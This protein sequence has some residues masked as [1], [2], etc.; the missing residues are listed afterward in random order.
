MTGNGEEATWPQ[1]DGTRATRAPGARIGAWVSGVLAA[2]QTR[3]AL[4]LPV[5]FGAG[6]GGYF[7]LATEPPIWAAP[8]FVVLA[9]IA[10]IV[11]RRH[12]LIVGIALAAT[13]AG[14]GVTVV[15]WRALSVA[16]PVLERRIGPVEVSGRVVAIDIRPADRR[17]VLDRVTLSGLE[18]AHTPVRIRV[19]MRKAPADLRPGDRV[20]LRAML[21]P[22]P[23]PAAPGAYDFQRQAWFEQLGAVGYALGAVRRTARG[24]ETTSGWRMRLDAVRLAMVERVTATLPGP[25][26]AVTATLLTGEQ[27]VVPPAEM[28][29]IR[30]SGLAHLLAISGLHVSLVAGIV[31][32]AI[33]GGLALVPPVALRYPIKKWA[34]VAAFVAI[35]LYALF[36]V[37][38]VPV[39]RAWLM[40]GVVLFAILIDRT[41][42]SMRL[43]GWAAFAVL[44]LAPESILSPSFQMSFAAVVALIAGWEALRGRFARWRA[45][46]GFGRRALQGLSAVAF[47]TF[48]AGMAS[49]PYALYHFNRFTLYGLVANLIAVPLTGLWVMPWAVMVYVLAPFGLDGPAL[50]AMGWGVEGILAVARMVAGWDGAVALLPAMPVWGLGAVTLG[51]LWLCL[52]QRGWQLAGVPVILLGLASIPLQRGPDVLVAGDA[53]LVAVR[54][55]DGLLQLSAQRAVRMTRETW[56]RRAGQDGAVLWPKDGIGIDGRLACDTDGCLYAAHGRTVALVRRIGALAEDCR[57]ASVVVATIPIRRDCP[58]AVVIDRFA[59]WRDGAHAIWL[60]GRIRVESVRGYRG[61][62]PWVLPAP[63]SRQKNATAGR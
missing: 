51:G 8:A 46:A 19:Q 36:V 42:I 10:A 15:Q 56:L 33:R 21:M 61:A 13:A 32:F 37:P 27:K 49:A 57:M 18:P 12:A 24:D 31:F 47:T 11:G 53:R 59:L 38:A 9:I 14:L 40:A 26:G 55:A 35:S 17:M 62:R 23:A 29:A 58:S 5:A 39:R 4:W 43:V 6:I 22:P 20:E 28:G 63:R 50:A 1:G 44:L 48:V 34:A 3:L 54:G 2:E 60:D 52:W 25:V 45:G 16:A 30:D 7:G 41:A